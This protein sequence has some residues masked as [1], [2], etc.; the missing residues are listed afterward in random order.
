MTSPDRDAILAAVRDGIE[1]LGSRIADVPPQA[2]TPC[3]DWSALDLVRHL[4]AIA[5]AYLLWAGS[6]V[7]GRVARLRTGRDLH[8]YNTLMLDRLPDLSVLD[9][10]RRFRDLAD[11]HVRLAR[12]T[13]TIPMLETPD[14]TVLAV[15]RHAGVAAV[16]WHV[17]AWDLGRAAGGGHR[18]DAATLPVLTAAWDQTL[19]EITGTDRDPG[20]DDWTSI[21]VASGRHP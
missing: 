4:E 1:A 21:L 3:A 9:H 2:P 20:Q 6:A 14:G 17:H 19:A 11:D 10:A 15:G 12:V 13:W 8:A 7:G 16:E 5:G 18:P